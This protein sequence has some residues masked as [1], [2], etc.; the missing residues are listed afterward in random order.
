MKVLVH[1]GFGIWLAARRLSPRTRRKLCFRRVFFNSETMC[2]LAL[3]GINL[4][5]HPFHLHG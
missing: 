4:G 2:D 5:K 1:D 3:V